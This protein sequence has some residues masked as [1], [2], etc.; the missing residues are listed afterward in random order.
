MNFTLIVCTYQ[1]P[2]PLIDLL[3]SVSVQSVYPNQI[4]IVDG[5]PNTHTEQALRAHHFK[6]L[7]YFRVEPEQRGLTKQR[8]FG[9]AQVDPLSEVV[10]FLDDDTVLTPDYFEEILAAFASDTN[11]VGV[12]G[13]AINENQWQPKKQGVQYPR[14]RFYEFEG[15]VYPEGLRNVVRHYLGLQ[16]PLPPGRMPEFS[17]GKTCSFPPTGKIYEVDLLVGMSFSFRKHL[18]EHLRFSTYFEGYGL[19]E[20]ADFSIRAQQFG[21]NVIST[22]ACLSHF[23]DPAGRPNKYRYGQMVVRNG[24]YVWR[25][26]YPDPSFTARFKWHAITLVLALIRLLNVVNTA[27]RQ[28]AFTEFAGRIIGWI[29]L[30][31]KKPTIQ[32]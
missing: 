15:F 31:L 23:H 6:N 12:G 27:Q 30:F 28:E 11:I 16:S 8:N 1:R 32:R 24:W 2:R 3:Q 7:V 18:F 10:C 9:I 5:S 19:Y 29:S 25:L 26:K 14:Q 13:I 4:V 17:H 21:K 22:R 20:D